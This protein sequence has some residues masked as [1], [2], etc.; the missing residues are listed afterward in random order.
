MNMGI[1][2]FLVATS[3]NLIQAQRLVRRVCEGARRRHRGRAV[4]AL[5]RH[6]LLRGRGTSS[7]SEGQGLRRLQRHRLQGPGRPVRG[8]GDQRGHPRAHPVGA[9]AVEMQ[10]E[11]PRGGDDPPHERPGEDRGSPEEVRETVTTI[12]EVG[13]AGSR[14]SGRY[15]W[16]SACTSCSRPWSEMGGTDLHVTTNSP[17]VIR[18]DGKL[19]RSTCPPLTAVE[20]KQLAYRSSPTRRS[21]ASRRTSSSTSASAS[22]AWPASA[23]TSSCS[24]ARWPRPSAR[25]RTRS[26]ASRSWG[27]PPWSP[28]SAT[29]RAG[30]CW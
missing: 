9:T 22:R 10:A 30:W 11:G 26:W 21:T 25:S 12:E 28:R 19:G 2:P 8:H 15:G 3:V 5:H 6:R 27:C 29:S 4:Q 23:P 17:P 13:R 16:R 7:R 14:R 18:V 24:A 1:E 20:T